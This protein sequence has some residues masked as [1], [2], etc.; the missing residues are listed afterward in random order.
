MKV[1]AEFWGPPAALTGMSNELPAL[2]IV[3]ILLLKED[4]WPPPC[5]VDLEA[6][7]QMT[8]ETGGFV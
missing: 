2:Q 3:Q 8:C 4:P 5:D 7:S 1:A 6:G